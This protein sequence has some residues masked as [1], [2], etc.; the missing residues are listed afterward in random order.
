MGCNLIKSGLSDVYASICI[1]LYNTVGPMGFLQLL[2][3]RQIKNHSS[4]TSLGFTFMTSLINL[5]AYLC[6]NITDVGVIFLNRLAVRCQHYH[7]GCLRH[8]R[9]WLKLII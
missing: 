9:R 8:N 6:L 3:V 2:F 4:A 1:V 5:A 7:H